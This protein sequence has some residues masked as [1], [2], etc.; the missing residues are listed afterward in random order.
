MMMGMARVASL[1]R[2][3]RQTSSPSVPGSMMSST[4]SAGPL[5][6]DLGQGGFTGVRL[7]DRVPLLLEVE[8]DELADVLLVLDDED[9][10]LDRHRN[11]L[12]GTLAGACEP[13]VTGR[14]N[15][16]RTIEPPLPRS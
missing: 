16:A 2:S 10:A 8:A 9:G 13:V 12:R 5:R 1:A 4:T 15:S 3:R 14:V 7:A 11:F 6:R